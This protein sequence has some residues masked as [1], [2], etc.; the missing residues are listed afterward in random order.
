[1]TPIP[2]AASLLAGFVLAHAAWSASDLP[3]G[4]LLVPLAVVEV[5]S[6]RHLQRFEA[7]VQ[8]KAIAAGKAAMQSAM[9]TADAWAFARDGLLERDGHKVDVISVDF[10]ARGM[11]SPA[12]LIQ[13]YRPFAPSGKFKIIGDPI[14]VI[15][16]VKQ[17]PAV[18]ADVLERVRAGIRSHPKVANLWSTWQ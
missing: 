4:E 3:K 12:T 10:W 5:K 11:S 13:E 2:E 15:D 16:G 6:E 17:S 9:S 1:V 8:D 18:V 7:S 14:I